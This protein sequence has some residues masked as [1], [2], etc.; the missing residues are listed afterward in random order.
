MLL[1]PRENL[2]LIVGTPV[3]TPFPPAGWLCAYVAL[4]ECHWWDQRWSGI[5]CRLHSRS[6]LVRW[7]AVPDWYQ[8]DLSCE[9]CRGDL[10]SSHVLQQLHCCFFSGIWCYTTQTG[11]LPSISLQNAF[12]SVL[13]LSILYHSAISCSKQCWNVNREDQQALA[14]TI[15]HYGINSVL[16]KS[17]NLCCIHSYSWLLLHPCL[18]CAVAALSHLLTLCNKESL[19]VCV[20]CRCCVCKHRVRDS[21]LGR[22]QYRKGLF[23]CSG[24][25]EQFRWTSTSL[26]MWLVCQKAVSPGRGQSW[27]LR[28]AAVAPFSH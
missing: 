27:L 28:V 13:D 21:L 16:S 6:A 25:V 12:S 7:S 17:T 2:I 10:T 15:Q 18:H 11:V 24:T 26:E 4:V 3:I 8:L 9:L 14:Q 19:L 1:K 20:T 5:L 23:C 22:R